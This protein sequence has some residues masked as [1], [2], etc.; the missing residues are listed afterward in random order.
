MPLLTIVEKQNGAWRGEEFD[1][2][3]ATLR[4][5]TPIYYQKTHPE[6]LVIVGMASVAQITR[7]LPNIRIA[8]SFL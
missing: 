6:I 5:V 7:A 3:R 4:P 1:T 2:L 8:V